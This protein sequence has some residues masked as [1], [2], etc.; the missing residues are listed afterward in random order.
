MMLLLLLVRLHDGLGNDNECV[1]LGSVELVVAALMIDGDVV[2][3]L[4][5]VV[6]VVVVSVHWCVCNRLDEFI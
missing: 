3:V 5:V 1:G 6:V 2:G 4:V